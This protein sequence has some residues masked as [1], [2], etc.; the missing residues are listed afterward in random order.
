MNETVK[1]GNLDHK[2]QNIESKWTG[3]VDTIIINNIKIR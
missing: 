3:I 2:W 1:Y